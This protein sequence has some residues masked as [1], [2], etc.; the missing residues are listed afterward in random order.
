M[1]N[2]KH[3]GVMLPPLGELAK[4]NDDKSDNKKSINPMA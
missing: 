3:G 1:Q 4:G 2:T